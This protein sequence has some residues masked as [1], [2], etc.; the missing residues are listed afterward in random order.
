MEVMRLSVSQKQKLTYSSETVY[1]IYLN[2]RSSFFFLRGVYK[3]RDK[4]KE[5][6]KK[7]FEF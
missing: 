7:D 3:E 5:R 1:H 2:S 4:K 6:E